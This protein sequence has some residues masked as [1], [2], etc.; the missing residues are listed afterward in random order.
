MMFTLSLLVQQRSLQ[1]SLEQSEARGAGD[2]GG[3]P[4]ES[5][6]LEELQEELARR[7]K[8][9]LEA[10]EERETLLA[11]LEELDGQNQEATQVRR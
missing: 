7:A 9:L 11:E 10:Q 4:G 1:A 2:G 3:G 5:L 6:D 8:R